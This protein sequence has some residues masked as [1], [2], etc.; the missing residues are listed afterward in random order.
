MVQDDESFGEYIVKRC[1]FY[2]YVPYNPS[3]DSKAHMPF[4]QILMHVLLV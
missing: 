2:R 4:A 3:F 1:I